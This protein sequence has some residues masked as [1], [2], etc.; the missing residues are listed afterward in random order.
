[1]ISSVNSGRGEARV[2]LLVGHRTSPTPGNETHAS[3]AE[4][5]RRRG[6]LLFGAMS[7]SVSWTGDFGAPPIAATG[8]KA[9]ER[10]L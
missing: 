6:R 4:R 10:A 1:M 8:R 2:P 9:A 3:L 7:S 5:R